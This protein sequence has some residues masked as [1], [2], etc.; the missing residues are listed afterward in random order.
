LEK[1]TVTLPLA[2]APSDIEKLDKCRE[3]DTAFPPERS[4][5]GRAILRYGMHRLLNGEV[6]IQHISNED[7]VADV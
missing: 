5:L 2:V 1:R 3:L 6:S 7:Y 4:R